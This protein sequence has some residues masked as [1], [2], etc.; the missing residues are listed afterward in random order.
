MCSNRFNVCAV[1]TECRYTRT[2]HFGVFF[3]F[4][5]R[6]RRMELLELSMLKPSLIYFNFFKTK[7]LFVIPIPSDFLHNTG[8]EIVFFISIFKFCTTYLMNRVKS[9]LLFR[10]SF[11]IECQQAVW[12]LFEEMTRIHFARKKIKFWN[13][14]NERVHYSAWRFYSRIESKTN[15]NFSTTYIC[16]KIPELTI[17]LQLSFW[18]ASE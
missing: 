3:T 5:L 2:P 7:I 17:F 8:S 18:R 9:I 16:F 15:V 10:F 13:R 6:K 4:V 1:Q 11:I 14:W 12:L